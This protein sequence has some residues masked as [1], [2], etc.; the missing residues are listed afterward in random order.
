MPTAKKK[1]PAKKRPVGR[2]TKYDSK[3][4]A[5][6]ATF[7]AK[8]FSFEAGCGHIG[9]HKDTGYE[10]VKKYSEF[11]DA[12]KD[13]EARGQAKLEQMAMDHLVGDKDTKFNSTVWIFMMKNRFGWRDKVELDGSISKDVNVTVTIG[14]DGDIF[15]EE[16][17]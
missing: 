7:M 12:K 4:C 8:G 1:A 13:G 15:R 3:M 10:W 5:K 6:L 17:D 16:D 9:I 14:E 2:P 11:S